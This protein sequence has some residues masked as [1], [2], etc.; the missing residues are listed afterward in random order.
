MHTSS[1][2]KKR[3]DR[4]IDATAVLFKAKT[5]GDKIDYDEFL[6]V[7]EMY[8]QFFQITSHIFGCCDQ[9]MKKHRFEEFNELI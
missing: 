5:K 4:L 3:I 8:I 2:N 1:L 9:L 6:D 7:L